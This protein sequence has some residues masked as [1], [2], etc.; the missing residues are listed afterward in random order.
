MRNLIKNIQNAYF[1]RIKAGLMG[2]P[3]ATGTSRVT[4]KKVTY[5]ILYY[6]F[7]G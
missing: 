3:I 1:S 6:P 2:S 4:E 5:L 7:N